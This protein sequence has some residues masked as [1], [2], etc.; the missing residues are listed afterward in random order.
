MDSLELYHWVKKTPK[1][2]IYSA[3]ESY[4]PLYPS[5]RDSLY[6]TTLLYSALNDGYSVYNRCSG[7]VT[8]RIPPLPVELSRVPNTPLKKNG[9]PSGWSASLLWKDGEQG[10][11]R[12]ILLGGD[13]AG[14]EACFSPLPPSF[15]PVGVG[16]ENRGTLAGA[17]LCHRLEQGGVAWQAVFFNRDSRPATIWFTFDRGENLPSGLLGRVLGPT[18]AASAEAWQSVTLAPHSSQK[19]WAVVGSAEYIGAFALKLQTARLALMGVTPNPLACGKRALVRFAL[20]PQGVREVRLALFDMRGRQVWQSRL[21]EGLQPGVNHFSLKPQALTG[22]RVAAGLYLLRMS[23]VSP[24][25]AL[26]NVGQMRLTII[27]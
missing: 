7:P 26:L 4:L 22:Q 27:P 2:T 21:E 15:S 8:L 5:L 14:G 11:P 3:V 17:S 25:G 1:D 23:A 18:P 16:L 10:S 20:P 9:R 24:E 19:R 12:R 13:E 6:S